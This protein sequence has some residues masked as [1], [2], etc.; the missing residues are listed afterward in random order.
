MMDNTVDGCCF[1]C[2]QLWEDTNHVLHCP[3]KSHCIA[4]KEALTIFQQHFTKQHTPDIMA[5]LLCTSM[6]SWLDCSCIAPLTWT[7][8][9]EPIMP[10]LARAFKSQ[11]KIGWNQFFSGWIAKRLETGHSHLLPQMTT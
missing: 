7:T 3:C 1:E 4:R 9:E 8:P 2:K 11:S 10:H 6:T 5:S